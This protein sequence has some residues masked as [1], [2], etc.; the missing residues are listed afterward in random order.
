M[1]LEIA[2]S[3]PGDCPICGMALEPKAVNADDDEDPELTD[4]SRCFWLWAILTFPVLASAMGK[5]IPGNPLGW[6]A[7]KHFWIWFRMIVSTPVIPWLGWPFF[8][9]AC[10]SILNSSLNMFTLLGLGVGVAER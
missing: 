8:V 6:A 2:R 5:Y 1:H 4:M 10:R 9:R 7:S 3:G